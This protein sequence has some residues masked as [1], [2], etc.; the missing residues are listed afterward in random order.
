MK[1]RNGFV[2]NSSSA[3]FVI[4]RKDFLTVDALKHIVEEHNKDWNGYEEKDHPKYKDMLKWIGEHPTFDNPL[5]YPWTT[6]Y[7]TWIWR[8]KNSI[9]YVNTCNNHPE[10]FDIPIFKGSDKTYDPDESWYKEMKEM[11]D[12]I[13]FFNFETKKFITYDDHWKDWKKKMEG[14]TQD[15][16]MKKDRKIFDELKEK[17]GWQ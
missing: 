14:Y 5:L 1:Q 10:L 12:K 7:E 11:R 17:Y 13:R 2:S 16:Q 15:V 8:G 3:S 9:L 4:N 6:N